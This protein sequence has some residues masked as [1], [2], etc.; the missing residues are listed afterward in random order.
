[1]TQEARIVFVPYVWKIKGKTRRLE[2]GTPVQCRAVDEALRRLDKVR[3][4]VL[5]VAGGRAYKMLVDEIAGDYGEPEILGEAGDVP[6]L[7]E[8]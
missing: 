1:M 8:G 2:E 7:D 4:G 6:S 5:S 3:S